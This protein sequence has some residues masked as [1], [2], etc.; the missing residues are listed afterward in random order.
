VT[1]PARAP[2]RPSLP[3]GGPILQTKLHQ[4]QTWLDGRADKGLAVALEAQARK[5]LISTEVQP[6]SIGRYPQEVEAAVYFCCLEALQ[7]ATNY[8]PHWVALSR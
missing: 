2:A 3:P 8:A 5:A 7:N 1:L 4:F 6:D